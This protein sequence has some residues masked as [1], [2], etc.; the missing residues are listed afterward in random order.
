[1]SIVTN[2]SNS[3]SSFLAESAAGSARTN[4]GGSASEFA[5]SLRKALGELGVQ[6]AEVHL[7]GGPA[8][9]GGANGFQFT[10][11]V[12][13]GSEGPVESAALAASA[14]DPLAG[15]QITREMWTEELLTGDLPNDVYMNVRDKAALMEARVERAHNPTGAV[16]R[17]DHDGSASPLNGSFLSTRQQAEEVRERLVSLGLDAGEIKEIGMG[18][19][20]SVDWGSESRRQYTISGFNVGLVLERYAKYPKE[21][22]DRMMIDQFSS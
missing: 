19:P 7:T 10:V 14:Y 13:G 16:V 9:A 3:L 8:V 17:G 11:T 18:G 20:F 12:P 15:P 21:L 4:A 22:A 1:M 6:G 5:S 2:K